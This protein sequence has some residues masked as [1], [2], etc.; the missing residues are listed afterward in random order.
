MINSIRTFLLAVLA[1]L[2]VTQ[3]RATVIPP[4][5]LAPGSPYQL[6]FVTGDTTAATSADIN[7]YNAFVNNAVIGADIW[8]LP[9]RVTWHAVVSTSTVNA[10]DNAPS[11]GLPVYN[12][13]GQLVAASS[14]YSGSLLAAVTYNQ[15]GG[16]YGVENAAVWTGSDP[17]GVGVPGQTLGGPATTA[18]VGIAGLAGSFWTRDYNAGLSGP[19]GIYALSDPITVPIPEPATL[20]LLGSALLLL[21]GFRLRRSRRP[22]R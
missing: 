12:T 21:G 11:G 7:Y 5:G 4:I 19:L 17:F 14:I 9:T 22:G 10:K 18:Q 13:A 6:I 8:G 15:F 1:L 20:T 3:V 16:G 2:Q